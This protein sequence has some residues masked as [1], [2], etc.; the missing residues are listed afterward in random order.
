MKLEMEMKVLAGA[1]SKAW[2]LEFTKAV[3]RLEKL[4]GSFQ[5]SK[6]NPAKD[7]DDTET[8]EA[9]T[10]SDDEDFT[11]APAKKAGRPKGSKNKPKSF[12]EDDESEEESEEEETE[13]E[14]S[15]ESEDEEESDAI[16]VA[17]MKKG[18]GKK[19]TVDMLNDAAKKLAASKG[20]AGRAHVLSLLKK[21]FK[22]ESVSEIDEA[23]YPKALKV[24]AS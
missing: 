17:E 23:D 20:K 21:H 9:D 13:S 14:E 16:D 3:D 2:L 11:S 4:A 7:E 12:D 5:A 24:L 1:E 22:T 19:I 18:K 6:G 10:D 15:E 8:V